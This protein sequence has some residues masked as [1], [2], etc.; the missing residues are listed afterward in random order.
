MIS[1]SLEGDA[2][3]WYNEEV[4]RESF[5]DWREFKT[6]L[7]ARFGTIKKQS[8]PEVLTESNT[9]FETEVV[10]DSVLVQ[11]AIE[12]EWAILE[13]K[14]IQISESIL[15]TELDLEVVA[16]NTET[17]LQVLETIEA[18]KSK[19]NEVFHNNESNS[20]KEVESVRK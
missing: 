3:S 15:I 12:D 13:T 9:F 2:H 19:E 20:E 14:T 16:T 17:M 7:L 10:H 18:P 4:R 11:E 6:R 1:L 5:K 8:P